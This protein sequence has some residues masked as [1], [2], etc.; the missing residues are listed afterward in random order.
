MLRSKFLSAIVLVATLMT[1]G[2]CSKSASTSSGDKTPKT[3]LSLSSAVSPEATQQAIDAAKKASLPQP[4]VSTPD[5]AYVELNKGRQLLFLH[6]AFSPTPVDYDVMAKSYSLDYQRA[7]DA[8]KKHDMLTT[9][10]PELDV[11][12]ADAYISYLDDR[13]QIGHYDFTKLLFPVGETLFDP[14]IGLKLDETGANNSGSWSL[15]NNISLTFIN[16]AAFQQFHVSDPAKARA[17]EALIGHL[18]VRIFAFVQS[19]DDSSYTVVQ[20]V[21]TKVQLL[22]PQ[23]QVLLETTGNKGSE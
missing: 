4:N 3:D 7:T 6:A 21:I 13:P 11:G 5:S 12:I 10:K 18:H 2:A 9:L 20:A 14:T 16:G 15:S 8:F 17:I 1:L 23:N 19:I 22:D